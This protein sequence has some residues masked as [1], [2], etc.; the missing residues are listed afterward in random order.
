MSPG[1]LFYLRERGLLLLLDLKLK[2]CGLPGSSLSRI[3]GYPQDGWRQ[4][5]REREIDR[6]RPDW[7]YAAGSGGAL[8]FTV[9]FIP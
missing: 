7:G 3:Q 4:Q 1:S 5:K 2:G 6:E 8:F 9:A